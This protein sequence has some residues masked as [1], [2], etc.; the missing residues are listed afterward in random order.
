MRSLVLLAAGFTAA[1]LLRAQQGAPQ[2]AP[3][4]DAS[5]A[6][7]VIKGE[8]LWGLAN[9]YLGDPFLWPEIYRLNT[10]KIEDP[11]WIYPGESLKL[12]AGGATMVKA[13][14]ARHLARLRRSEQTRQRSAIPLWQIPRSR[15][16]SR[17]RAA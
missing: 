1:A 4:G 6:H 9:E 16:V 17:R 7:V 10:D 15:S 3:Q 5:R 13:E 2:G 12:P 8:T 14:Q 11:H